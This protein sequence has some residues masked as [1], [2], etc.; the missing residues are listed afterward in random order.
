M[1]IL[2]AEHMRPLFPKVTAASPEAQFLKTGC[3]MKEM[4]IIFTVP[5]DE[6]FSHQAEA[7]NLNFKLGKNVDKCKVVSL[8]K[9]LIFYLNKIR[10]K[11]QKLRVCFRFGYFSMTGKNLQFHC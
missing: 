6:I 8:N 2:R 4:N 7:L 3:Q 10:N 1:S 5:P 11:L 9:I